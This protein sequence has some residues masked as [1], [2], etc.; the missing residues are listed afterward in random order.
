MEYVPCIGNSS[1]SFWWILLKLYRCFKDGLEI[2]ILFFQNPEIIF[3]HFFR[4]FNL[5]IFR[6]L[7]LQICIWSIYLVSA[8]PPT[9]FGESFW[10]FTVV[11]RMVWR[12][13]Y[14]FLRILK[15]FF[16]HFN[17][18]IFSSR[19][20]TDMYR[21]YMP[22]IGN[23]AY[24]FRPILLKLY[25]YFAASLWFHMRNLSLAGYNCSGGASCMACSF[26][27]HMVCS[28]VMA[29]LEQHELLSDRQ[30]ALRKNHYCKTQLTVVINDWAKI[31]GHWWTNWLFNLGLLKGF[32][33]TSLLQCYAIVFYLHVPLHK[34]REKWIQIWSFGCPDFLCVTQ[35]WTWGWVI[36]LLK[37]I[38]NYLKILISLM[39]PF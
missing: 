32:W 18:D 2:C 6:A 9:V 35:L 16:L 30:H 1:Y 13:A 17:L 37:I 11:F 29:H 26:I 10:N 36:Q 12:Y 39:F 23:P 34:F 14:C 27:D 15:L 28:N 25:R 33:N 5:D 3:Y 22:C 4:I 20:A 19:Y 31:L 8:T 21:E 24:S 38:L 7:I